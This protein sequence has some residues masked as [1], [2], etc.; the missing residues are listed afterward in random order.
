MQIV[1]QTAVP[2]IVLLSALILSVAPAVAGGDARLDHHH[3]GRANWYWVEVT[4]FMVF[5]LFA[6]ET[7][8]ET[9][10]REQNAVAQV[11]ATELL[12]QRFT[13]LE[14]RILNMENQ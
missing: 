8:R 11:E 7:I 5:M 1:Y 14:Q 12:E 4:A 9:L 13:S 6:P 3:T 10:L 2:L